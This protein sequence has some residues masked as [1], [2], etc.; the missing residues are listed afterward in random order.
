M[1]VEFLNT[2]AIMEN[3]MK[4]RVNKKSDPRNMQLFVKY[5]ALKIIDLDSKVRK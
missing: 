3:G 2:I 5:P 4:V 1:I